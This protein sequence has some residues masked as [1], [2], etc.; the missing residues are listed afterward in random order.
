M[1]E[2]ESQSMFTQKHENQHLKQYLL[3]F[4]QDE[5]SDEKK[6][7]IKYLVDYIEFELQ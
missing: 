5:N 7:D 4:M 1:N 2:D 3:Y 6:V